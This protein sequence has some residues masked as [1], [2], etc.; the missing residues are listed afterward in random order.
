MLFE[1]VTFDRNNLFGNYKLQCLKQLINKFMP[2]NRSLF[3]EIKNACKQRS[4]FLKF[5]VYF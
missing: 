5:N 4:G 3:I 2:P 1:V